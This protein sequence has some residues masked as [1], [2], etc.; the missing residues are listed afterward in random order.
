MRHKLIVPL[1]AV[2]IAYVILVAEPVPVPTDK[3]VM[4]V[5]SFEYMRKVETTGGHLRICVINQR[6]NKT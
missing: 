2:T 4:L 5:F 1:E 3:C 6:K